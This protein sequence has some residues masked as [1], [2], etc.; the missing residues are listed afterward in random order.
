MRRGH[1]A[2]GA[3]DDRCQGPPVRQCCEQ[4]FTRFIVDRKAQID[5]HEAY[6][7]SITVERKLFDKYLAEK[8]AGAGAA[9]QSDARLLSWIR[10]VTTSCPAIC[11]PRERRWRSSRRS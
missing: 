2:V 9:A 10:T 1:R 8:A 6:W 4:N 3:G 5:N 11:W 7:R